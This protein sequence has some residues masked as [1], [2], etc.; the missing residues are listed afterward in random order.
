M[1]FILVITS[2]IFLNFSIIYCFAFEQRQN[3]DILK[4]GLIV[5]LSGEQGEIGKSILNSLRL[6]LSKINDD[7]VEIFPRDNK[8]NPEKTLMVAKQLESEGIQIIIGP[9]FHE[10][11]IY[12]EEVENLIFL[13]LITSQFLNPSLH[14]RFFIN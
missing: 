8:S 10:N 5:P 14:K 2:F 9:I 13:S 1:K 7:K 6:G 12:L 11:L 3:N 4:I